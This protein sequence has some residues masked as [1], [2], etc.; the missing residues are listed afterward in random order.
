MGA[1]VLS[2]AVTAGTSL[3]LQV[4]AARTLGLTGFGIF[5]LCLSLLVTASA[6]YTGYIGDSLA[7]LDRQDRDTRAALACSA[8]IAWALCFVAGLGTILVLRQ[9]DVGTALVYGAMLVLWLGEETFR[10][11][12]IA[13]LAFWRLVI[14]DL[15]YFAVTIL[16]LLGISLV[17]GPMTLTA[18]FGAMAIGAVAAIGV[19]IAQVPRAELGEL[20]PGLAGMRMV[21]SFAAWRALQASLRPAALLA[22]RVFVT[23]LLSLAAVGVLEAGRLVVAPLQVIINGAGSFLLAG[24]AAGEGSSRNLSRYAVALLLGTTVVGGAGLALFAGPLGE[25]MTGAGVEPALVLGWVGYLAVWAAGLPYVTE[26]VAR[27]RSRTVFLVRLVDSV[28]GLCL[29]AI[30][31]ALGAGVVAVPWLMSV[32]GIYSVLRLRRLA[33][34]TRPA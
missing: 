11:L 31:L 25:L 26:V 21:A 30:A 20:R 8:L 3:V 2:Q 28:V 1:P 24:F 7:V 9:G 18:L 12:L 29:V 13:R 14:N 23:N 5:A 15:V 16:V 27:R 19:G 22:S 33:I 10:R 4:I 34:R 32:G 17:A 6:L